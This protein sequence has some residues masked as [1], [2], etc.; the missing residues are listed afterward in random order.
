MNDVKATIGS[1]LSE[2]IIL[3]LHD[4]DGNLKQR[5]IVKPNSEPIIEYMNKEE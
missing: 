1:G 2:T 5:N 4:K 3:E